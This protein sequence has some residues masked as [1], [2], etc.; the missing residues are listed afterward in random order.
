MKTTCPD[1]LALDVQRGVLDSLEML[2]TLYDYN[3]S[4]YA[5]IRPFLKGSVC[6]VGC[7]IL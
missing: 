6:E 4:A 3:H 2:G 1:A 5:K 7:G